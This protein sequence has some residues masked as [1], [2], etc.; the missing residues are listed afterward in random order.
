MR[1]NYAI[2]DETGKCYDLHNCTFCICDKFHVPVDYI[3]VQYLSGYY[4][5]LP[6]FVDDDTDFTGEWYSDPAHT[7][8]GVAH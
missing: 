6:E 4:W 3:D 8:K 2:V 5:P 1:Y 7:I